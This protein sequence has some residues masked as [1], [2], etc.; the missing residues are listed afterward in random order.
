MKCSKWHENVTFILESLC[1]HRHLSDK[2]PNM[3]EL[4]QCMLFTCMSSVEQIQDLGKWSDF[5]IETLAIVWSQASMYCKMSCRQSCLRLYNSAHKIL[6]RIKQ[7][8]IVPAV[9]KGLHSLLC[10]FFIAKF[11][12]HISNQVIAKVVA[13]IHFFNLSILHMKKGNDKLH[14]LY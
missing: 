3:S 1:S 4:E 6:Y 14:I 9:I 8:T 2:I 11:H 13:D 12:I 7:H 5:Q 10:I